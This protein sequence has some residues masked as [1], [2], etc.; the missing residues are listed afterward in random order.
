MPTYRIFR[1]KEAPRETFRWAAHTGGLALVKVRDYE[2]SG[3]I[4]ALTPYAAWKVLTAQA[5]PIG[6]GDLLEAVTSDGSAGELTIAKYIGFE[7]AQWYVPELKPELKAEAIISAGSSSVG[8]SV[9]K[10]SVPQES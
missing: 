9:P 10:I 3:Q 5:N 2:P 8:T 7:P 4:E 6:P 1:M